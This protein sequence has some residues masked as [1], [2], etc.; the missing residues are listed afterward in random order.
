MPDTVYTQEDCAWEFSARMAGGYV[1]SIAAQLLELH[2]LNRQTPDDLGI[3]C[4]IG[5]I[6]QNCAGENGE[7]WRAAMVA[8][9]TAF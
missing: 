8:A 2:A 5:K 6:K 9:G 1:Y 7:R 4:G 3:S